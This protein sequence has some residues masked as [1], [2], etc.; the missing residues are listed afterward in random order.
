MQVAAAD[1]N[2]KSRRIWILAA[3]LKRLA[4]DNARSCVELIRQVAYADRDRGNGNSPPLTNAT[5]TASSY[6]AR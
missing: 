4:R 3:D 1:A 2:V 5:T 6:T